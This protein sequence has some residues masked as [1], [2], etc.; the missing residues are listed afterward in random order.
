[1]EIEILRPRL[2]PTEMTAHWA[3]LQTLD[4][5]LASPFLSP[6]WPR[7][8]ERAFEHPD[9]GVRIAMAHSGGR[10][11]G[12]LAARCDGSTAMGAGA[13][14]CDYQAFVAEPE[15][16]LDPRCLV[17]A[18]GVGRFDFT[19]M[20]ADDSAFASY[21]KGRAASWVVDLEAGYEGYAAERR[22]A[23][24]TVLKDLDKKR[25]KAKRELAPVVFTARSTKR[26]DFET[27]FCWKR[28]QL[29]ATGQV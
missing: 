6:Q 24:S 5:D 16:M 25:R 8:V 7:F 1:M 3:R 19:H 23:G 29:A 12:Y 26:E 22:D 14:M 2:M 17:Q 13:P 20:L 18:L 28:S 10:P 21:A 15:A 4:P 9:R 11:I 27:L